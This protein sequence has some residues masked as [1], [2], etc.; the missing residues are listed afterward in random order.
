MLDMTRNEVC[1]L[2]MAEKIVAVSEI[3]ESSGETSPIEYDGVPY[4]ILHTRF[5]RKRPASKEKSM[6]TSISEGSDEELSF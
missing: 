5:A 1:E 2:M 3:L 4:G 6:R